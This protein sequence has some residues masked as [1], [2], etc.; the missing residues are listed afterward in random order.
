MHTAGNLQ[1][2]VKKHCGFD[3]VVVN[4]GP[5]SHFLGKQ[6]FNIINRIFQN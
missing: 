6:A 5:N 4:I 1:A 3:D 2:K